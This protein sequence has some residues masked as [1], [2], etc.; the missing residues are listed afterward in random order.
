M[1]LVAP[2]NPRRLRTL[3]AAEQARTGL[4]KLLTPRSEIPAVTHVDNSARVQTVDGLDNPPYARLLREFEA[5]TGCPVIINTSFN[6]RGEP[7]VGTP[8]DA[9]RCFL[10]TNMDA[11]ALGPFVLEKTRQLPPERDAALLREFELD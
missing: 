1:L 6:V 7:I 5:L 4:E 9:L 11:L 2:V 10:R 3:T 8:A